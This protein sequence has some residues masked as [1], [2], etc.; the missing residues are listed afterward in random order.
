MV[1]FLLKVFQR[2][3]PENVHDVKCLR[4]VM[5]ALDAIFCNASTRVM[6][7]IALGVVES[8]KW[9]CGKVIRQI[10]DLCTFQ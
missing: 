7:P 2:M 5:K 4:Y 9:S 3:N 10:V 8:S 6:L 1:V